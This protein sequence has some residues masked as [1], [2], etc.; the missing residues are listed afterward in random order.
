MKELFKKIADL[1]KGVK[2][3]DLKASWFFFYEGE[4]PKM[5]KDKLAE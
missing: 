1:I 5:L 3:K 2:P 4:E